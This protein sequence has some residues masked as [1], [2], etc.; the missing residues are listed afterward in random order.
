M[1][2]RLL[3]VV[4]VAAVILLVAVLLKVSPLRVAGQGAPAKPGAEGEAKTGT[5]HRAPSKWRREW[6]GTHFLLLL[7]SVSSHSLKSCASEAC[8]RSISS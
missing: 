6:N 2:R 7:V 3:E 5:P 8:G 4:G 1:R